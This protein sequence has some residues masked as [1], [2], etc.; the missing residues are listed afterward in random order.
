MSAL[1]VQR[2]LGV[3]QDKNHLCGEKPL[4]P[5]KE[6]S[7]PVCGAQLRRSDFAMQ[8][9]LAVALVSALLGHA[10]AQMT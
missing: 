9:W 2:A 8:S 10:A 5:P 7:S 6:I 1:E 3:A 4:I